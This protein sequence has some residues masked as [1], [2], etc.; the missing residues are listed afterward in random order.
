MQRLL[1]ATPEST[2]QT[3]VFHNT[4]A[5]STLFAALFAMLAEALHDD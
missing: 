3:G 5:R 4:V 1:N 2:V